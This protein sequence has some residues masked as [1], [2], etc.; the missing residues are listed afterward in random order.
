MAINESMY[1]DRC[2]DVP[3]LYQREKIRHCQF[4]G[5]ER[6]SKFNGNAITLYSLVEVL[7]TTQ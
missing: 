6:N 3:E 7:E 4:K 2:P 5:I 1:L